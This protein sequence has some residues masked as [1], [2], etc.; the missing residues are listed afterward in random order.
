MSKLCLS[1]SRGLALTLWGQDLMPCFR[2]WVLELEV[3]LLCRDAGSNSFRG[4][5]SK[6]LLR[7]TSLVRRSR[8]NFIKE[9]LGQR[10]L[11][12]CNWKRFQLM[13]AIIRMWKRIRTAGSRREAKAR[14]QHGYYP[15]YTRRTRPMTGYLAFHLIDLC[16]TDLLEALYNQGILQ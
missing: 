3:L 7:W 2:S 11:L 12:L 13:C 4:R 16:L 14:G 15:A 6:L 5:R 9:R 10:V 8:F 1:A